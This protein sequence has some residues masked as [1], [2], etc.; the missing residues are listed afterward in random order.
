DYTP[1]FVKRYANVGEI[2]TK[3]VAAY[4][5]EIENGLFPSAEYEFDLSDEVIEKLY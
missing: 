2:I 5:H 1:K 3:A 4:C